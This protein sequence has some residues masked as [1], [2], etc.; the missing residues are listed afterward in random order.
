[1]ASNCDATI[2]LQTAPKDEIDLKDADT[3]GVY[4]LTVKPDNVAPLNPNRP[5]VV[6]VH[7]YGPGTKTARMSATFL[8]GSTAAWISDLAGY[9]GRPLRPGE[10]VIFSGR[11]IRGA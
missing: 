6:V 2:Q 5:E 3:G 8:S 10:R 1:M 7:W 9:R 4:V 11:M